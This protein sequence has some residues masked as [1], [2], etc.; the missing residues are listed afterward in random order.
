MSN[1][2]SKALQRK[3]Q[4]IMNAIQLV[5]LCKRRLQIMRDEGWDSFLEELC[6]FRQQH[7]LDV[8]N[9]DDMLSVIDLQLQELNDCF[10][11]VNIELLLCIACMSLYLTIHLKLIYLTCAQTKIEGLNDL[12]DLAE[13]LVLTKK[14][15]ENINQQPQSSQAYF[16]E[17]ADYLPQSSP[18]DY[19]PQ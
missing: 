1:E 19:L 16:L 9:M 11:E 15:K 8:S 14:Y 7:Y 18:A 4:D 6:S 3:D 2:L 10:V 12:G 17:L 13:K 5:R